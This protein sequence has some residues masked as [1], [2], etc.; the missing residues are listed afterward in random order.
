MPAVER[1]RITAANFTLGATLPLGTKLVGRSGSM[2]YRTDHISHDLFDA[3]A[4]DEELLNGTSVDVP[5][6]LDRDEKRNPREEDRRLA[7]QLL[8]HLNERIEYYHQAIWLAMDANRRYLLLDGYLAPNAGGRSVASVVENRLIGIVGYCLV[9]PV[10]PGT[11][12]D[13]Q[14][15]TISEERASLVDLYAADAPPPRRSSVPTKGVYAEAVMGACNS[16]EKI[17]DKRFWRWEESPSPDEPPG[18]LPPSTASRRTTPADLTPDQFPSPIVG[19]QQVP[20]EPDPTGLAAALRLI[21][22]PNLFRDLTG[23]DLNQ[24]AAAQAFSTALDTA[25]FFGNQA[26]TL[27]QQQFQN[28]EMDRNLKRIQDAR[29]QHLITDDQARTLTQSALRSAAGGR[30]S[31][32]APT[33]M[34][35]V[36]RAIQR[37]STSPSGEVSVTL[38]AGSVSVRS[39]DQATTGPITFDVSPA[40][41]AIAQ[42]SPNTCWAAAGATLMSWHRRLVTPLIVTAAADQLGGGWRS[43]LDAD[44]PLTVAETVSYTG[45]LGLRSEA[46][47]DYLRRGILRLL[48]TYGPLLVIG[49]N[50]IAGDQLV[51][52][53]IVTGIRGDGSPDGTAVRYIDPADGGSHDETFTGFSAQI[54]ASDAV[55]TNL[56]VMHF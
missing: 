9:L 28:R 48:Q 47:M 35:A 21:G 18:I 13:P 29:D 43:L 23:L 24:Q 55:A 33:S 40:V 53:R 46:P 7:T 10:V 16:C 54:D 42:P 49:D 25:Q 51:H 4:V 34:P 1:S 31:G 19:Y 8:A 5:V 22:T 37:A 30:N 45:A 38:P 44:H 26:A 39:G 20:Q 52:A 14:W 3:Y 11:H 41:P 6:R 12:L 50:A 32:P 27:A 15:K 36:Q 56:G 2:H 17:D